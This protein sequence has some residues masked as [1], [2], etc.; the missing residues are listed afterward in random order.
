MSLKIVTLWYAVI[1]LPVTRLWYSAFLDPDNETNRSAPFDLL[2]TMMMMCI[3]LIQVL[4]SVFCEFEI[5]SSIII[6]QYLVCDIKR[7]RL[8]QNKLH[9]LPSSLPSPQFPLGWPMFLIAF[10]LGPRD[11]SH[12]KV[13]CR[14]EQLPCAH[15]A[16]FS[17]TSL[18]LERF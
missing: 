11:D 14:S 5:S 10:M 7:R 1:H 3:R 6:N 9:S 4:T 18:F 16:A 13:R 17:R 15:V 12:I 2:K 8:V